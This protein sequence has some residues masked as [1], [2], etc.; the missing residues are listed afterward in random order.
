MSEDNYVNNEIVV[1]TQDYDDGFDS[2][3]KIDENKNVLVD[4]FWIN[5]GKLDETTKKVIVDIIL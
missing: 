2:E 5:D 4:G 1:G 3:N